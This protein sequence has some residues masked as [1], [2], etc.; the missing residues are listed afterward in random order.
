MNY[1]F[2]LQT[3]IENIQEIA[4]GALNNKNPNVK[5]ETA[6]FLARAFAYCTPVSLPKKLLKLYVTDLLKTLNESGMI[7]NN[8]IQVSVL[9]D[10][11]LLDPTVRDNSAEALG[12]ALKV[13]GEK[14]L[15]PFIADIDPLKNQ[16]VICK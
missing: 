16:K 14:V 4:C 3:N 1:F 6:S 7:I 10:Y 12:V 5:A 2:Y 11:I 13:V 15:D 8:R 9:I